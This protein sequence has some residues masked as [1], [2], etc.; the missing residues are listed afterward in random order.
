MDEKSDKSDDK[1]HHQ[2]KRVQVKSDGRVELSNLDPGPESLCERIRGRRR[3]D[4]GCS[5][6]DS[7]QRCGA[8][9]TRAHTSDNALSQS[10]PKEPE[11]E[12]ADKGQER[13]KPK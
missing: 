11:N 13:N 8:D 3:S 5:Y 10:R 9:G 2:G 6:Q 4:K 1:H 12:K 7:K